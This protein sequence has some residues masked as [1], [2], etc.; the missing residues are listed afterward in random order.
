MPEKN[1]STGQ[2]LAVFPARV[3]EFMDYLA[4]ERNFYLHTRDGYESD[5]R[6][7]Y[8]FL[9][10]EGRWGVEPAPAR[11][12]RSCRYLVRLQA[13]RRMPEGVDSKEAFRHKVIFQIS[14]KERPGGF[15]P[16][17][18]GRYPE[19]RKVPPCRAYRRGGKKP[20]RGPCPEKRGGGR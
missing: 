4:V 10:E 14:N 19:S 1:G 20:R 18:A 6:Q 11:R 5:L 7:F 9:K 16:G 8:E 12:E 15:Q 3:C 13:S 2:D 17:G